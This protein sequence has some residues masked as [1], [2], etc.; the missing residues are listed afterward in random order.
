MRAAATVV[1]V[2]LLA[3]CGSETKPSAEPKA[4][5]TPSVTPTATQSPTPIP[6]PRTG[7][8]VITADSKYGR[9]LYA[10]DGQPIY[11][12]E[13]ERTSTPRCYGECAEAWPPVLTKGL[14]RAKKGTRESL[15]GTTKRKGGQLQVTYAGHPLYFYAHEGKY[16]VLCHDITEYG[17][18]WLVVQPNGR[19]APG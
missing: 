11:L 1:A 12:F 6:K 13:L 15:L 17:G 5:R 2:A 18:T 8:V 14:P 9:M 19:A 7:T 10:A 3:A 4:T 16:Q